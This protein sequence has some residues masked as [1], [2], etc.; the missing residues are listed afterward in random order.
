MIKEMGIILVAIGCVFLVIPLLWAISCALSFILP[1]TLLAIVLVYSGFD[2]RRLCRKRENRLALYF[3]FFFLLAVVLS[4]VVLFA[5][6][7]YVTP[8]L[9]I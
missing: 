3:L 8:K 4:F 5:I 9:L 2:I 1:L 6:F 7:P